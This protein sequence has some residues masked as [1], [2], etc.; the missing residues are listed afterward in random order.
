MHQ[1]IQAFGGIIAVIGLVVAGWAYNN[2]FNGSGFPL[3][4]SGLSILLGGAVLYCFGAMVDHLRA[5]RRNTERQLAIF[6]QRLGGDR[7]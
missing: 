1:I 5:I 7:T 6:E 2:S 4:A 3:V